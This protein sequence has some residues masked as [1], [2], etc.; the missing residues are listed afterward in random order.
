MPRGFLGGS[1]S[2][3]N[4]CRPRN[5]TDGV[6]YTHS[7]DSLAMSGPDLSLP[8]VNP[9]AG[10]LGRLLESLVGRLPACPIALAG[11]MPAPHRSR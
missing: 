9:H 4:D 3:S 6:P 11:K 1:C 2:F 10:R 7:C 8:M 5:A